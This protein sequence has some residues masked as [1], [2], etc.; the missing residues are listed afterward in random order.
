M[1]DV[2]IS[3]SRKDKAFVQ[4]LY[5]SLKN[6]QRDIWVDWEDIPPTAD[7]RAEIRSGIEAANAVI[8]VITPDSVR[9]KECR[10]ELELALENNKRLVPLMYRMITDQADHDAMHPALNAHNWVYLRDEDDFNAGFQTLT[11]GLDT[12]LSYVRSH[13]RLQVRAREWTAQNQDSSLLLRGKDLTEAEAWLAGAVNKQPEPTPL[14]IEYIAASRRAEVARS[15]RLLA[16]VSVA[17]VISA[18][19]AVLAFGQWQQAAANLDLAN[20]R[21]TQVAFQAATSDANAILAQNNAATAVYNEGRSHSIALAA[22]A[23]VDLNSVHP[24]RAVVLGLDALQNYPYT[25]QAEQVLASSVRNFHLI[26]LETEA[27]ASVAWSPDGDYFAVGRIDGSITFYEAN[28]LAPD[29]Y[30][31]SPVSEITSVAWSPDS[32]HIAAVGVNGAILIQNMDDSS[33][34]V[35][36]QSAESGM[37]G[38]DWSPEGTKIVTANVDHTAQ[39]WNAEDGSLLLTLEGHEDAVNSAAW[40][41]DGTKIATASSDDTVRIWDAETGDELLTLS[42]HDDHVYSVAWS[43][44]GSELVTASD[45]KT[46]KVWNAQTGAVRLTISG[47]ADYVD[48]AAWS[49]DG[50]KILTT[51]DDKTA[52]I[53]DSTVGDELLTLSGHSDSVWEGDW[54]PDGTEVITVSGDGT[55]RVWD[56]TQPADPHTYAGNDT[57]PVLSPDESQI[58]AADDG[59]VTVSDAETGDTLLTFDSHS[60]F[61]NEIQWSE[62]GE[63]LITASEDKTVQVWDAATGKVLLTLNHP[64]MPFVRA[65]WSQDGQYIFTAAEYD[66]EYNYEAQLWDAATGKLL[67]T[68]LTDGT[69]PI[70]SPDGRKVAVEWVEDATGLTNTTVFEGA[71][72][73]TLFVLQNASVYD[74]SADGSRLVGDFNDPEK[75]HPTAA[76]WDGETG[77]VIMQAEPGMLFYA[78]S[79]DGTLMAGQYFDQ[80]DDDFAS[81]VW[82]IQTGE[83][84]RTLPMVTFL[85][86]LPDSKNL[87]MSTYNPESADVTTR[88]YESITDQPSFTFEDMGTGPKEVLWGRNGNEIILLLNDY[89]V[90]IWDL[91]TEEN[92]LTLRGHNAP[93]KSLDWSPDETRI[94]TGSEDKTA[95]VW[96]AATGAEL[97][98]LP[99]HSDSVTEVFWL[100]NGGHII[101]VSDDDVIKVWRAWETTQDLMDSAEACCVIRYLTSD[102]EQQFGLY[103]DAETPTAPTG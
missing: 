61:V 68:S 1:T 53:W 26:A 71:S 96:D 65:N 95:K 39:I 20:V 45:D 62:E 50:E 49:P 88:F 13:T 43:P 2:F 79:P 59:I 5:E 3:Y 28:P 17:L 35:A 75:G 70:W 42:G 14:H 33:D 101:T 64:D 16:G 54:S 6:Q 48:S 63:K 4:K 18:L 41:P 37:R 44:D 97:Y 73:Q 99:G 92:T 55:I 66:S 72:G 90:K 100:E 7:W 67:F 51:S 69:T 93:V 40:S 32:R 38:V 58:A 82:D 103:S 23:Q 15:R 30:I 81:V 9:S 21:G 89:G 84:V 83:V 80:G 11:K 86:W 29:F 77:A 19:L 98:T 60:D 85:T 76:I 10:V 47:H 56:V 74:W 78:S 46:A 94:V 52:R 36:I 27:A 12:D 24:D 22:Q 87:V 91:Q 25:A 34:V 57:A 31:T 8:F 102:E